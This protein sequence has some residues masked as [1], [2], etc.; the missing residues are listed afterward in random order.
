VV[1]FLSETKDA[2]VMSRWADEA[3]PAGLIKT[4]SSEHMSVVSTT[5]AMDAAHNIPPEFEMTERI[6]DVTDGSSD[7]KQRMFFTPVIPLE[8][9]GTT[10]CLCHLPPDSVESARVAARQWIEDRRAKLTMI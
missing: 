3:S 7:A 2:G 5:I 1:E 6:E 4:R 10:Y 8:D 9:G